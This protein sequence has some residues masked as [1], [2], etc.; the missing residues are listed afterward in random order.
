MTDTLQFFA[1]SADKNAGKGT[2][3]IVADENEYEELNKIRHWRRMFS[4]FWSEDPFIFEGKTYLSYEHAYQAAK[5]QINGYGNEANRFCLES[6][7]KISRLV[8]KDV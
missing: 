5:Y 7:D 2:G 8:G 3:D 6:G 1:F 4:S